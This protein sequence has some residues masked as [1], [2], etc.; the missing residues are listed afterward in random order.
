MYQRFKILQPDLL[1]SGEFLQIP[2]KIF[3][4]HHLIERVH[5]CPVKRIFTYAA[6]RVHS[7]QRRLHYLVCER[8]GDLLRLLIVGKVL[9]LIIPVHHR[10][11]AHLISAVVHSQIPEEPVVA[12]HYAVDHLSLFAVFL[13]EILLRLAPHFFIV[14]FLLPASAKA[15]KRK[16]GGYDPQQSLPYSIHL[17]FISILILHGSTSPKIIDFIK[18]KTQPID[19]PYKV[20]YC[21]IVLIT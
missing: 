14:N 21:L 16:P 4:V 19:N 8:C 1:F 5:I 11:V 3:P 2:V 20:Y 7:S 15:D 6:I 10:A 9:F 13:F 12:R 18:N 17:L